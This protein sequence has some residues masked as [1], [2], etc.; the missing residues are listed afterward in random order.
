M[1]S[2]VANDERKQ[3]E[4]TSCSWVLQEL[5]CVSLEMTLALNLSATGPV[6][7]SANISCMQDTCSVRHH[8][9]ES[10]LPDHLLAA[11]FAPSFLSRLSATASLPFFA[12]SV[13]YY[14][15]LPDIPP[16]Y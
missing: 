2:L 12:F 8:R 5:C 1:V 15:H 16:L 11:S 13:K 10:I 6:G 4:W 14:F 3:L 9:N 7:S